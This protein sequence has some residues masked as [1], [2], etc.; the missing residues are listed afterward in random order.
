MSEAAVSECAKCG[1]VMSRKVCP[2]C[3]W[4]RVGRT[5]QAF[6]FLLIVGLALV[7]VVAA[8]VIFGIMTS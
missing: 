6:R 7:V 4:E 3:G 5:E 2:A 1:T 8:V